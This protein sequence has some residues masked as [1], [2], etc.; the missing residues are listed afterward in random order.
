MTEVAYVDSSALVKLVLDEPD[1]PAMFRWYVE[2]LNVVTSRIGV[3][4]TRRAAAR[5]KHDPEHL[6]VI[7]DSIGVVE[8]NEAI[9]RSAAAVG[10]APLRTLDAIHLATAVALA[11]DLDAFVTYDDRL[12]EA[13]RAIGLPVVRPV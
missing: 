7:L 8:L 1:S 2:S 4:E 3:V 11:P 13:A 5:G 6:G 12:A 10:P 9:A